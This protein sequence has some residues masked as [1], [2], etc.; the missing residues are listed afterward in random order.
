MAK[1]EQTAHKE[2]PAREERRGLLVEA[3]MADA[4]DKLMQMRVDPRAHVRDAIARVCALKFPDQAGEIA[5]KNMIAALPERIRELVEGSK[6]EALRVVLFDFEQECARAV[7]PRP[8]ATIQDQLR[9]RAEIFRLKRWSSEEIGAIRFHAKDG[10]LLGEVKADRIHIGDR[11]VTRRQLRKGMHPVWSRE[12]S[13]LLRQCEEMEAEAL[14]EENAPPEK[15]ENLRTMTERGITFG[16]DAPLAQ[17]AQRAQ[18]EANG[19]SPAKEKARRAVED[20]RAP[21]LRQELDKTF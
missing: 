1:G 21:G 8:T 6:I 2:A 4:N 3:A 10:E 13:G 11:F 9:S 14:R 12:D 18:D 5:V 19:V 17:A 15:P 7:R 16:P 20:Q